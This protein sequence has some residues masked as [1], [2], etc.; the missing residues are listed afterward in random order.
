MILYNSYD[1]KYINMLFQAKRTYFLH[2]YVIDMFYLC[3]NSVVFQ[4]NKNFTKI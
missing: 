3:I 4:K 2:L 1:L